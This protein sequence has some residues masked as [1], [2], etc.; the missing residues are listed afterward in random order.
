MK[1]IEKLNTKQEGEETMFSLK[2]IPK[3]KQTLDICI[4]AVK[5]DYTEYLYIRDDIKESSIE[6]ANTAFDNDVFALELIPDKFKTQEMC[7]KAFSENEKLIEFIPDQFK[8]KEMVSKAIDSDGIL[9]KY[10]KN[11]LDEDL[12][13][14]AVISCPRVFRSLP[15]ELQTTKLRNIFN[16]SHFVQMNNISIENRGTTYAIPFKKL[17]LSYNSGNIIFDMVNENETFPNSGK[18]LISGVPQKILS[19]EEV[20]NKIKDLIEKRQYEQQEQRQEIQTNSKK[21]SHSHGR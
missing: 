3:E 10:C 11:F 15:D 8:T 14:K 12:A 16:I 17:Q 1:M 2:Y 13:K 19:F 7:N 9:A 6:L 18:V 5:Q 4:E 21:R 20:S